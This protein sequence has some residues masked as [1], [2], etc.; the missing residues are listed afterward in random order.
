MSTVKSTGSDST[1]SGRHRNIVAARSTKKEHDSPQL[2]WHSMQLV[3]RSHKNTPQEKL[4]GHKLGFTTI[5]GIDAISVTANL[6][7]FSPLTAILNHLA[8]DKEEFRQMVTHCRITGEVGVYSKKTPNLLFVPPMRGFTEKRRPIEYYITEILQIANS[9][10]L[11][12]L[13]FS[14]FGFVNGGYDEVKQEILKIFTILL[15]PVIRT[16]LEVFYWE[17]DSNCLG[18]IQKTHSYIDKNFYRNN[19]SNPAVLIAPELKFEDFNHN[20]PRPTL[21]ELRE[22]RFWNSISGY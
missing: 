3:F 5:D 9:R 8:H 22:E 16:T 15:N 17:I 18:D 1:K 4:L 19:S 13:H 7:D 6:N 10:N 20:P 2:T 14:H 12:T 11:K 21:L